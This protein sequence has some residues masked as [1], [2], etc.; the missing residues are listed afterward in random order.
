MPKT[1]TETLPKP[2]PISAARLVA[3]VQIVIRMTPEGREAIRK[4]ADRE[5]LTIQ[6]LGHY[7]WSL[8]LREYGEAPLPESLA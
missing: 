8:A 1:E 2:R 6:Q 4:V 3:P 5:G 7:A